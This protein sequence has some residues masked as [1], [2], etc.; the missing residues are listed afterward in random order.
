MKL[1][2]DIHERDTHSFILKQEGSPTRH[3]CNYAPECLGGGDDV[4]LIIDPET[5]VILNWDKEKILAWIKEE[6]SRYG[7]NTDPRK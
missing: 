3:Y 7:W 1:I 4:R 6:D 5:G 2:Y